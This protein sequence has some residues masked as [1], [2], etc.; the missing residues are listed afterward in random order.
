MGHSWTLNVMPLYAQTLRTLSPESG[1]SK[2]FLEAHLSPIYI[3]I[4]GRSKSGDSE[5]SPKNFRMLLT[6]RFQLN[7]WKM[8]WLDHH[9]YAFIYGHEA[10]RSILPRQNNHMPS[11]RYWKDPKRVSSEANKTL[12]CQ[13][14]RLLIHF[15]NPPLA[16][17]RQERGD[18]KMEF[19]FR[20]VWVL[21]Q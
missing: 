13:Q 12:P 21:I 15:R 16:S 7:M 2:S 3:L 20:L 10:S 11:S 9:L 1:R 8:L 19:L 5:F 14:S 4:F 6:Q 17:D 18:F